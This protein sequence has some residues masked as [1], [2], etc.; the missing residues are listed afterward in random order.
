MFFWERE[1]D[2]P[3]IE[4]IV[5]GDLEKVRALKERKDQVMAT[6]YLGF[7]AIEMARYLD[8]EE[9]L[10]LLEPPRSKTF[11][12]RPKGEDKIRLMEEAEFESFFKIRYLR[13]VI[14][15]SYSLFKEVIRNCPAYFMKG[16]AIE[17][18][19]TYALFEKYAEAP[20][21]FAILAKL[22]KEKIGQGYFVPVTIEWVEEAVG[23][24]A[25]AEEEIKKGSFV[26]EYIGEMRRSAFWGFTCDYAIDYPG[27]R[28][29]YVD[30]TKYGNE[31]RFMNHSYS[32]NLYTVAAED[33]GLL[34]S[35]FLAKR[36]ISK[37]EQ[38]VWNYG[39]SYWS[40]RNPPQQL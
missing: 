8:K 19:P 38:L 23:Y 17:E 29:F 16:E 32:P 31:A 2:T 30:A 1:D 24:G 11:K 15:G 20:E 37:G 21:K 12:V 10:R 13:N 22:H 7:N 5:R 35:V 4:A 25:F 18:A 6:N 27:W 33:R 36:D 14:Y 34:H 39:E 40:I 9:C 26:G 3:L 28:R